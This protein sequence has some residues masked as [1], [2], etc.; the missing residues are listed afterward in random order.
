MLKCYGL[1]QDNERVDR[2]TYPDTTA[3]VAD[4]RRTH[5]PPAI[6]SVA[7]SAGTPRKSPSAAW[8]S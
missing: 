4:G 6:V 2:T 5:V 8:R 7:A 1:Q 3:D